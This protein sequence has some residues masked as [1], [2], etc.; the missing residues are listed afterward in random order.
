[1]SR[2]VTGPSHERRVAPPGRGPRPSSTGRGF[3]KVAGRFR[4]PGGP[5]G[6][7]KSA[8]ERV[9][10]TV[11]HEHILA[12]AARLSDDALLARVKA[13]SVR[14][15]DATVELVGHLAELDARRAHL[16]EGPGSRGLR[17]GAGKARVT[18]RPTW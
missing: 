4:P 1:M 18:Y 8:A 7:W 5:A 14:E 2:D 16:G 17:A 12:A 9:L 15:R 6:A 13:L 11:M 3:A 10:H